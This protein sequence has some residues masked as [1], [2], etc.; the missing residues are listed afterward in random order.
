MQRGMAL[1]VVLWMLAALFICGRL[2]T[3]VRDQAQ[4]ALVQRNLVQGQAIGEAAMY[5]A[6]GK[7]PARKP[8]P[9][10]RK[11]WLLPLH[12]IRCKSIFSRGLAWSISTRHLLPPGRRCPPR[13]RPECAAGWCA[14]ANHRQHPR[15]NAPR[16][17]KGLFQL[18][19]SG[20]PPGSW[21]VLVTALTYNCNLIWSP[22]RK[23]P[24]PLVRM[25]PHQN[26]CVGFQAQ[27]PEQIHASVDNDGLYTRGIGSLSRWNGARKAA[28]GFCWQK[29]PATGLPWVL[30]ASTAAW[31]P[32]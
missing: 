7:N 4:Q 18:G 15:A 26:F 22:A 28:S 30:L 16:A 6:L 2:G 25:Q 5:L 20:H 21:L 17:G 11:P 19:S 8:P 24:V 32:Q 29:H 9:R 1:I 31:H 13:S 12:T 27:A 23:I 3:L 14:G 10:G